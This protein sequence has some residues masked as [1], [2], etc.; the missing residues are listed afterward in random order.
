MNIKDIE[1]LKNVKCEYCG[2]DIYDYYNL[3]NEPDNFPDYIP[4]HW[5][6]SEYCYLRDQDN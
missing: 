4:E 5:Y 2:I 3:E 6:C 1:S